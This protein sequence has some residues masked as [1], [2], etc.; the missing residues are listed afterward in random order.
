MI[1]QQWT[2]ILEATQ[3]VNHVN[4]WNCVNVLIETKPAKEDLSGQRFVKTC[5]QV[6][7]VSWSKVKA[8]AA[9]DRVRRRN[10]L[11]II[12]QGTGGTKC[13]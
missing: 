1:L 11:S 13:C 10:M 4:R 3:L 6:R 5:I 8:T 12:S 9:A 7:G 2:K